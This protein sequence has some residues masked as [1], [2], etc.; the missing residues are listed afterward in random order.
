MNWIHVDQGTKQC[1]G[2]CARGNK[3]KKYFITEGEFLVQLSK[4]SAQWS[5]LFTEYVRLT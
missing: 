4:E 3:E 5:R 2:S 1:R